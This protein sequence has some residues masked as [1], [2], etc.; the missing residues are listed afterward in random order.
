MTDRKRRYN[1]ATARYAAAK[2]MFPQA[3]WMI[4]VVYI[5]PIGILLIAAISN[6]S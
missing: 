4:V 2:N 3:A 1:S 6:Q 5:I